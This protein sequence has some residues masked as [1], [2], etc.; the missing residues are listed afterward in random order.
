MGPG[1]PL[2]PTRP[3]PKGTDYSLANRSDVCISDSGQ[4]SRNW[5]VALLNS[6]SSRACGEYVS[7]E[8]LYCCLL[9]SILTPTICETVR[10]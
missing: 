9:S 4:T 3:S 2:S 5:D 7:K 1:F 10:E 8:I 6:M